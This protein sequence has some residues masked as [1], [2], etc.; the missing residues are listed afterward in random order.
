ML[1]V[2]LSRWNMLC[3]WSTPALAGI[4]KYAVGLYGG[5]SVQ[6]VGGWLSLVRVSGG[7]DGEGDR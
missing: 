1:T 7:G 4:P 6:R 2:V 3:L 5:L